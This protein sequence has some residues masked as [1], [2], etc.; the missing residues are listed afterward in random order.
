MSLTY[1]LGIRLYT[2]GIHAVAPFNIKARQWVDGRKNLL[3]TIEKTVDHSKPIMWIHAPSLGEFEQGRPVIEAFRKQYPD[4]AIVLTFFSPSGYEVRKN[5]NGVDYVFYLPADTKRNARKFCELLNP[6]VAMFVKYDFWR[7]YLYQLKKRGTPTYVFS[8]IFRPQ[9]LFFKWYGG[10][11]RKLLR[12]FTS[13][14]VQ[15]ENSRNLLLTI[16]IQNVK[17]GGDTRFDRVYDLVSQAKSQPLI[18][19]F[20]GSDKVIVAG[21][22]W[23]DDEQ[24]LLNYVNN[25]DVK[26][27]IAPHETHAANVERIESYSKKKIVRYSVAQNDASVLIEAKVLII[28]CIGL[29]SSL[30]K[31]GQMAYI[32]GGFGKGIHNTLE[33]ATYGVPVVFGPKYQKFREACQLIEIGAA[34]S[35]NN[36]DEITAAFDAYFADNQLCT[37]SGKKAANYVDQMRGG[38]K[39]ILEQVAIDLGKK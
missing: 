1:N 12:C 25:H 38:T 19:L 17:I 3:Q 37:E 26:L 13:I 23:I 10:W 2:L 5:Y 7:N 9:Q 8:S 14:F 6:S 4:Y 16:G 24:L 20:A 22:T 30:Y 39:L 29:L 21:S 35:I 33:A 28:D 34:K 36:I 15:D 27:I 18:E 31:Y 32:G 11:Y